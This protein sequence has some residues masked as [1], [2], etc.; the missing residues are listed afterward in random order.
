MTAFVNYKGGPREEELIELVVNKGII[1][2]TYKTAAKDLFAYLEEI[3]ENQDELANLERGFVD[4]CQRIAGIDVTTEMIK[5]NRVRKNVVGKRIRPSVIEPSFGL[6]RILY[7]LLEQSYY[8]R[9]GDDSSRAVLS[10]APFIAPVQCAIFPLLSDER[11][12]IVVEKISADLKKRRISTHIDSSGVSIGR[13]YSRVDEI[14]CPYCVTVDHQTLEDQTV[15][16][17]ERDSTEQV[18]IRIEVLPTELTL[19][20]YDSDFTWAQM[21]E[22]YPIVQV[23]E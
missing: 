22:K 16:I 6:G 13:R 2:K 23:V 8:T 11:F 3:K 14:G 21:K 9:P 19:L 18:R 12:E 17:R 1:G 10:L 5:F 15:T 4:G 20:I 7:S